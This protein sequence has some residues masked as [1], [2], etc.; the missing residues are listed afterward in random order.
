[1]TDIGIIGAGPVGQ[2]HASPFRRS[3]RGDRDPDKG[4]ARKAKG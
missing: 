1:M 2:W 3:R 4:I